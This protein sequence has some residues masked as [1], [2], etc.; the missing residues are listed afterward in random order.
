[1]ATVFMPALGSGYAVMAIVPL[2]LNFALGLD[3]I[4]V[5]NPHRCSNPIAFGV[6]EARVDFDRSRSTCE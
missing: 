6:L 3:K 5:T 1:M 4:V 2:Q